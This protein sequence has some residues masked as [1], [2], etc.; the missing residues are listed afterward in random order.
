M[1]LQYRWPTPGR[2]RFVVIIKRK[3]L[4]HQNTFCRAFYPMDEIPLQF[5][6]RCGKR[7]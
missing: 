4:R 5:N 7:N 1:F 2:S 3:D 6:D